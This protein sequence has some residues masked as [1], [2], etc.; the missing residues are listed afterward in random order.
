ME[1]CNHRKF[2][3]VAEALFI[4]AIYITSRDSFHI[5]C[6]QLDFIK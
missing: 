4:A 2:P 1:L 5:Y 6:I 3:K